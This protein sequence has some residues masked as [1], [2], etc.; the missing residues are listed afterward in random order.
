MQLSAERG[1]K[2][3]APSVT[4]LEQEDARYA[5]GDCARAPRGWT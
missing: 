1:I 2:L 4:Q 3:N 5:E